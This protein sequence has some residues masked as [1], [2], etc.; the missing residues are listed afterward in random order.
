VNQ[1]GAN[2]D[3]AYGGRSSLSMRALTLLRRARVLLYLAVLVVI[4]IVAGHSNLAYTLGIL[5]FVVGLLV[6]VI[7]HEAGHFLTAKLF[8]MKA[9]QFFIGFGATLWSFTWGETE[10]GVK[11]LPFGAFVKITGMTTVDPVDP[12]DEARAM[13][14]KP[15]WQRAIVMVAGSFMH[16]LLAFVLLIFLALAIG[17]TNTNTTT[18][19]AISACVPANAKA[20]DELSCKGGKGSSPAKLAGVKPGDQIIAI[21]G[22]PVH[23]W[24]QIGNA[25]KTQPA[26]HQTTVTV[27]RDGKQ[28]TLKLTPVAIPGRKG[29]IL[30][31]VAA[32]VFQ[33]LSPVRSV[34]F[35]GSAFGQILVGS[36]QAAGSLPAEIPALFNK[37]RH[38]TSGVT[39]VVGVAQIAGQA[40]EY[41]GG[42]QYTVFDLLEILISINIFIGAFNLLPL[43]PLDGGH[44]AMLGYEKVRAWLA[45][46]R[47][48]PDPGVA[49][50]QPLI[51]VSA[52]VF[53]ILIGLG[54]LLMA[55]N[56]YNPVHV[57]Q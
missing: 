53:V 57:I 37:N 18:V 30:G 46:L 48:R 8:G 21:G 42:W 39:S 7:L 20:Y 9:T 43:L 10:Y 24:T 56:L 52:A 35:A 49:D 44:L 55:A 38:T 31:I 1:D 13:R 36:A 32:E 41:G 28:I 54:V 47:G 23:S 27:L 22:K 2:R 16:F 26:G 11:A 14:N 45:Q 5:I 40:V 3:S 12:A 25:I 19:G 34:S 15:R 4:V 17:Q 50:L 33:P 51:P 6:S 29:P